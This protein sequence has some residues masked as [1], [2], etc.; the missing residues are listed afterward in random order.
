MLSNDKPNTRLPANP[1]SEKG[2]VFQLWWL[3]P[4]F[5]LFMVA[6]IPRSLTLGQFL[7]A[8]EFLWVDRAK[9][10]LAGMSNNEF[11]C[12]TRIVGQ[13]VAHGLACT[14][15]TGHPGVTTMWSG[16]WGFIL[17]WLWAGQP[18][19]L[20]DYVIAVS[21]NPLD[22]SY[23]AWE[24]FGVVLVT[25]L[26]IVVVYGLSKRLF[27]WQAAF[28]AALLMALNPFHVALSR[29]IHHDALSTSFMLLSVLCAFLYWGQGDTPALTIKQN[30]LQRHKLWLILS[31]MCAGFA[32]LSKL[33]A[34]FLGPMIALTGFWFTWR[35][36]SKNVRVSDIKMHALLL[37]MDGLLWFGVSLLIFVA[38]WPAMWVAPLKTLEVVFFL[39]SAYSSGG[40]AKGVFFLGEVVDDPG[41]LF[42]PVTWL[43][44]TSPLVMG[45]LLG[46]VGVLFQYRRMEKQSQFGRYISRFKSYL[47]LMVVFIIAYTIMMA[48]V[49]KKQERYLLPIYPWIDLLAGLGW[50]GLILLVVDYGNWAKKISQKHAL[51]GIAM[52]IMLT[53][54]YFLVSHAPYY[55]TYYNP[56]LGGIS[57][58][59]HAVTLGWGEGLD[60]AADYLNQQGPPYPRVTSWYQSTFAPYYQGETLSYSKEKGKALA[61]DYVTFYINQIQRNYPD[62]P[63]FDYYRRRSE[64]IKT[65]SLKGVDHVWIYPSLGVDHYVDDQTYTGIASLL[66]WQWLDGDQP[67][68]AGQTAEFELYWEYIGKSVDEPFFFQIEDKQ[69]RVWNRGQSRLLERENLPQTEWR[70]GEMLVERGVLAIP[71]HMPPGQYRL[72][73]GFQTK[74]EAVTKGE[75]F[76]ELPPDECLITVESAQP[77]DTLPVEATPINQPLTEK[78]TLLGVTPP[79]IEGTQISTSMYWRIEQPIPADVHLHVGLMD[80]NGEAKQAWFNLTLAETIKPE[81]T[82][83]QTGDVFRTD[84]QLDLLPDLPAGKYQLELV[85]AE[86]ITKILRVDRSIQVE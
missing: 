5:I 50:A 38:F 40:H 43:Y 6:F 33:P 58:A 19:S 20:H 26:S 7:T 69:G 53:N 23:L 82:T 71:R 39:G 12:L 55:F 48:V 30:F 29:V 54:G 62:E 85:W 45:G 51:S 46:L 9:N 22:A 73:I 25:A 77:D 34:L 35:Q 8:D 59:E 56:L 61:G 65:I 80:E 15:R 28:L 84:W 81:Q 17:S 70:M 41:L 60:L 76:F 52:L 18:S 64:P 67:L 79:Q 27:G 11:E 68:N 66:A 57:R 24:R 83:W 75:L 37:I 63:F 44:R 1:S 72:R 74:A 86:D 2:R 21:T 47:P 16:V 78:L 32:F 3:L 49:A 4:Y 42:Y 13:E 14:V 10:F 31:G 36:V